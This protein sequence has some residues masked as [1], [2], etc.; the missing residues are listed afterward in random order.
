MFRH[1]FLSYSGKII[2]SLI[3]EI[4]YF[5]VWWY[6]VGFFRIAK[7]IRRFVRGREQVLGF[8]VWLKNIFVPMYGQYDWA[9]RLI[10][11]FIR[12]IQIIFRGGVLFFWGGI[13]L[14]LTISWLALPVLLVLA[15]AF[16][17]LK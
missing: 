16:Q 6:S 2:I 1:N 4:V 10:S 15:L 12:L 14:F 9:G 13:C 17:I 11:F 7:N 5:P 3:L 8:S